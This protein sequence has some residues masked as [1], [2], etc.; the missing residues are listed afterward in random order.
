M[1]EQN[2]PLAGLGRGKP[3]PTVREQGNAE[4]LRNDPPAVITGTSQSL[5]DEVE[6][7][8]ADEKEKSDAAKLQEQLAI[9]DHA[10]AISLDQK[11]TQYTSHPISNFRVG[12]FRFDK[13][14]LRLDSDDASEFEAL[15]KTLPPTESSRVRKLDVEAAERIVRQRMA[16][17]PGATKSIDSSIGERPDLSASVGTGRLGDESE[18]FTNRAQQD[19][20]VPVH[21]DDPS[22]ELTAADAAEGQEADNAE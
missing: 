8:R 18:A 3:Q 9:Q 5:I 2:N 20:N 16:S 4:S 11:G 15:L 13:G 22:K 12:R 14:L 10:N 6:N 17:A 7:R 19:M 21:G 1:A